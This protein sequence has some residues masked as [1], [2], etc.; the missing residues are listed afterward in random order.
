M[1][2][3]NKLISWL[4][5]WWSN[6]DRAYQASTEPTEHRSEPSSVLM[7]R[8]QVQF[9]RLVKLRARVE[10]VK[11]RSRLGSLTP[12]IVWANPKANPLS[13][14]KIGPT[15][16]D[17]ME[18]SHD[19][20]DM[21]IGDGLTMTWTSFLKFEN[22]LEWAWRAKMLVFNLLTKN[23][24]VRGPITIWPSTISL[25]RFRHSPLGCEKQGPDTWDELRR[26]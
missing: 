26:A 6:F 18:N 20:R 24:L 21:S 15:Q 17:L 9:L 16:H 13:T 8:A 5:I 3:V 2:K 10:P 23:M 22:N 1:K 11:A 25:A 7:F 14:H 4:N 12:I 19:T